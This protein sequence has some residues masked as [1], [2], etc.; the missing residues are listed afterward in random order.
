MKTSELKNMI[1]ESIREVLSEQNTLKLL[2]TE[3]LKTSIGLILENTNRGSHGNF[4]KE[5]KSEQDIMR[6]NAQFSRNMSKGIAKV[7]APKKEQLFKNTDPMLSKMMAMTSIDD[8][9]EE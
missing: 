4:N 5:E 1:K 6:E 8:F 2:F 9:E 7:N 3:S